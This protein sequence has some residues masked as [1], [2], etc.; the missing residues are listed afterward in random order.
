[1]AKGQMVRNS[2]RRCSSFSQRTLRP[3]AF[4]LTREKAFN[5]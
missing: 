5:R 1:M 3:K 2:N 4:L